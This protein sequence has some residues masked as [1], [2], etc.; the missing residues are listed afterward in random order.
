MVGDLGEKWFRRRGGFTG[1][2]GVVSVAFCH[3]GVVVSAAKS[4]RS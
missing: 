1:G 4:E 3:G 2:S